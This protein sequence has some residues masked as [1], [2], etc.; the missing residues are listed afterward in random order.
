MLQEE[1]DILAVKI[2]ED[3]DSKNPGTIF[4]KKN[5]VE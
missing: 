1:L 5:K 2:L 3:Y 4:K